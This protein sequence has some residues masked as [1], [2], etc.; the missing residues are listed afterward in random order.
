M[1]AIAFIFLKNKPG[2][3]N[4]KMPK[5]IEVNRSWSI[6]NIFCSHW[7]DLHLNRRSYMGAHVL[8]ILL[9]ESGGGGGEDKMRGFAKH[10]INFT[11]Q[12]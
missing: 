5:L 9:N 6:Q 10:L 3:K 1:P 7:H 11:Q 12:V 2:I 4:Y 8:L